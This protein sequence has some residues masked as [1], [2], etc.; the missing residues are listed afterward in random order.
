MHSPLEHVASCSLQAVDGR[1]G[2]GLAESI[3]I[4]LV[5]NY[6]IMDHCKKYIYI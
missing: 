3:K 6:N 1:V 2:C 4:K 5:L